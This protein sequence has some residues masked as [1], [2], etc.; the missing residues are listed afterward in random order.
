MKLANPFVFLSLLWVIDIV[1]I[2]ILFCH[3]L[4]ETGLTQYKGR[5][6]KGWV[7]GPK[8]ALFVLGCVKLPQ[9]TIS[10]RKWRKMD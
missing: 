2:K 9:T 1:K 10:R 5:V 4:S 7:L 8:V 3:Y 6:R